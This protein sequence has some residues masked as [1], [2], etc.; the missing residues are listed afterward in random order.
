MDNLATGERVLFS[1]AQA[2]RILID[3]NLDFSNPKIFN[4]SDFST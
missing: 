1:I 4:V 3:T 2:D